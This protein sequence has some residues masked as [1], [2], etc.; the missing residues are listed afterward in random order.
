MANKFSYEQSL[1][2][3]ETLLAEL[4]T[5]DIG[6]DELFEQVKKA[7]G[8]ITKLK[9]KLFDAENKVMDLLKDDET[10]YA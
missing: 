4:E 2:E 10:G 3:L 9:K 5:G 8:L 1:E 7:T 6:I